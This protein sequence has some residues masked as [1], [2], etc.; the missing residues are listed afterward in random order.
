[1]MAPFVS[2]QMR[3]MMLFWMMVISPCSSDW[4]RKQ[5]TSLLDLK[6]DVTKIIFI[7]LHNL[8]FLGFTADITILII[9]K[10]FPQPTKD[11]ERYLRFTAHCRVRC[12]KLSET[13]QIRTL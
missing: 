9:K 8:L 11:I 4:N 10:V 2:L 13:I 6:V 7:I 5:L 12:H 3:V 1:M